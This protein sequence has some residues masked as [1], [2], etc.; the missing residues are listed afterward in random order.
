MFF[1]KGN[2]KEKIFGHHTPSWIIQYYKVTTNNTVA[3]RLHGNFSQ[4]TLLKKKVEWTS[5]GRGG[6]LRA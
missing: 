5:I 3:S 6:M 2:I 1:L 4:C